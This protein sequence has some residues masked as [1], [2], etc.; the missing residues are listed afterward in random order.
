MQYYVDFMHSMI[1]TN[2]D[3]MPPYTVLYICIHIITTMVMNN[4]I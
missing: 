4:E 2:N 3:I 1:V